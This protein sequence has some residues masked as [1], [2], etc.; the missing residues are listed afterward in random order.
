MPYSAPLAIC[1]DCLDTISAIDILTT[2]QAKRCPPCHKL[3]RQRQEE[4]A[5]ERPLAI[6]GS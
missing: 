4:F 2:H 3:W 5:D 1:L 6:K